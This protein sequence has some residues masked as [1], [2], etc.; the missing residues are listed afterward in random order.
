MRVIII[1][2]IVTIISILFILLCNYL[3]NKYSHIFKKET[4][5]KI[6]TVPIFKDNIV[7]IYDDNR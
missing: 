1:S 5:E 3:Y 6:E 4:F 2:I 7:N